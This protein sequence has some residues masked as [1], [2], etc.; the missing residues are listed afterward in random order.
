MARAVFRESVTPFRTGGAGP[1][2]PRVHGRGARA[3]HPCR[4]DA[5]LLVSELFGNGVRHSGPGAAGK[6]VT[7]T[8]QAAGGVVRV[9][10]TDRG[11]PGV[12]QLRAC[13]GEA[14]DGRGL[15]GLVAVCVPRISSVAV[16]SRVALLAV[17]P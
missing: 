9:E 14:E 10:V 12:P 3:G 17:R 15:G 8:V 16:T 2:C 7:V 6:T 1:G 5:A 13:G 11:G 4:D